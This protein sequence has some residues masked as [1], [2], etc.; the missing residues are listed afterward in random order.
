MTSTASV[1]A[2]NRLQ[3]RSIQEYLDRA[4]DNLLDSFP[5]PQQLSAD[6]G[7]GI[8]ARYT[9]VLE[10]NFIY[11]MT[12][13]YLSAGSEEARS[14]IL[15]NLLEEVRDC[16]PGMLRRFAMAAHAVPTD[17]DALAVY[18]D[19]MNVRLFV[20][21][22]SGVQILLMMTFFEGFIQRFMVFLA[23]LA[24]RQGS[25]EQEY[26]DVHGVCDVAHTQELLRALRAEMSLNPPAPEMNLLEGVDLL[27]TLIV[28]IV[29]PAVN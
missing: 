3:G 14:I 21:R 6:Q 26:T 22:L 20:G 12:G 9:A 1:Q 10:G 27:R 2:L 23:E 29:H 5:D 11:W 18:R 13:A 8:V 4:I 16:H 17:S 19:L 15:G 28:T 24:R 7:R 25:V